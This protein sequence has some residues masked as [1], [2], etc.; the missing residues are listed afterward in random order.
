MNCSVVEDGLP[1][2]H[3]HTLES[4]ESDWAVGDLLSCSV[5]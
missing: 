3:R 1:A 2:M 5:D 4:K